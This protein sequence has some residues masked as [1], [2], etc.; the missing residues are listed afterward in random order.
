[1]MIFDGISL[2][3]RATFKWNFASCPTKFGKIFCGKLW[4]LVMIIES[5]RRLHGSTEQAE[6]KLLTFNS[7]YGS[8][9]APLLTYSDVLFENCEV[10]IGMHSAVA[11]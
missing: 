1:M 6:V 7:N 8:F 5:Y 9:L 11:H 10:P 3:L 4:A 2:D